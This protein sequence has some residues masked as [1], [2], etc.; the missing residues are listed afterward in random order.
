MKRIFG[1]AALMFLFG[2]FFLYP[3][4]AVT[5]GGPDQARC[6]NNCRNIHEAHILGIIGTFQQSGN[7]DK[8]RSDTKAAIAALQK[9][10]RR[11]NLLP[12]S[13]KPIKKDINK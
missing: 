8:Y 3:A 6:E 10:L 5:P 1:I 11:C 7:V 12:I 9:C 2:L 4:H 13:A